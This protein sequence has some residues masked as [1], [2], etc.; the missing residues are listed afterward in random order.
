MVVQAIL[1]L[2]A[3]LLAV[4]TLVQ[5]VRTHRTFNSKMD[6]MLK[7]TRESSFAAGRKAE[8]DHSKG[9]S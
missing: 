4:A 8:A 1:V 6:A 2:P 3:T 5:G 9:K 7:L